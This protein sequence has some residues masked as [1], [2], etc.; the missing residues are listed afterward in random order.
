MGSVLFRGRFL[1][2]FALA[3]VLALVFAGCDTADS[4]ENSEN[5]ENAPGITEPPVPSFYV[6]CDGSDDNY[7]GQT[8]KTPFQTLMKAYEA[9]LADPLCK[10][11]V[12]L[13]NLREAGLIELKPI[14]EYGSADTPILIEGKS[15]QRTIERSDG[16]DDSVIAVTGG[17]KIIFKNIR[18]NGKIAPA[19]D[20]E[21]ANNRALAVGGE[22]TEV[23]LGNGVVI[24]GQKYASTS[25]GPPHGSGIRVYEKAK[26]VMEGGSAV[27]NCVGL[28]E[29]RGAV[30]VQ[31]GGTLEINE[32]ARIFENTTQNGGG[33][34][35]IHRL[36]GAPDMSTLIMNG[37]EI[38]GNTAGARGGGVFFLNS[39]FIMNSGKISG[40][41]ASSSDGGGVFISNGSSFTMVDGEISGNTAAANG[42]GVYLWNSAASSF[43]MTG[44]IIYGS[45]TDAPKNNT[46]ASG[47]AF[48]KGASG[49]TDLVTT[50]STINK[51]PSL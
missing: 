25:D 13:S 26:L 30:M 9:A 14:G 27:T 33:G 29:C 2:A 8:E 37:G 34:I 49:T 40:N 11:I 46:A 23:T 16:A 4:G 42:G 12:I 20:T 50:D 22:G 24:T 44:G 48:Y 36:D 38:S 32:D 1:T 45:T 39:E 10:Q 17:M 3:I 35:Y 6:H 43:T 7:D 47:A 51:R 21:N 31:S 18:I 19:V 28:S 41:T 5:D 15:G